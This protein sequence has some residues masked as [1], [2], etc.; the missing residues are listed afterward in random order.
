MRTAAVNGTFARGIFRLTAFFFPFSFGRVAPPDSDRVSIGF[1]MWRQEGLL[2]LTA[3]FFPFPF[4]WL[5]RL[6]GSFD[7]IIWFQEGLLRLIEFY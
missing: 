1:L 4:G 5:L 6:M 7:L 2:H 3:F